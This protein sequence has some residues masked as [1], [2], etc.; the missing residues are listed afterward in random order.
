[1]YVR[2]LVNNQI[3]S[4]YVS[5]KAVGW[6]IVGLISGRGT[7][8]SGAALRRAEPPDRSA[9]EVFRGCKEAETRVCTPAS[10]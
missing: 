4:I 3:S 7:T 9:T 6:T 5:I 1:M 10:I 2:Q 8:S